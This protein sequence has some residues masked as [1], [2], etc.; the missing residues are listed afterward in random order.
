METTG[1]FNQ[2]NP[3]IKFSQLCSITKDRI[4]SFLP[5][6]WE[7]LFKVNTKNIP[8]QQSPTP[9]KP[10]EPVEA[11]ESPV[12]DSKLNAPSQELEQPAVAEVSSNENVATKN[13]PSVNKVSDIQDL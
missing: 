4:E 6:L 7:D 9:I 11:A 10:T 12:E 3:D 8:Q 5:G 2:N 13:E 1:L